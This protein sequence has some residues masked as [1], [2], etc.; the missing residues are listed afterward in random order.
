MIHSA[1]SRFQ[2]YYKEDS[3]ETSIAKNAFVID[4]SAKDLCRETASY[5]DI[6]KKKTKKNK[7][8]KKKKKTYINI[9]LEGNKWLQGGWQKWSTT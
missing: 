1:A 9:V 3:K 2:K 8:N 5:E 4:F 7:N 6:K